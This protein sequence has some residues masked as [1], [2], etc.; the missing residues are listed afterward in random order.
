MRRWVRHVA[1]VAVLGAGFVVAPLPTF[2]WASDVETRT[3]QPVLEA[4][5]VSARAQGLVEEPAAVDEN[6]HAL[7]GDPA[8]ARAAGESGLDPF[9]AIG[10][11]TATAPSV[12]TAIRTLTDGR[13]SEW[14]ELSTD[15]DHRPDGSEGDGSRPG[16]TSEPLFVERADGYEL[17]VPDDVRSIEV[18]LVT[19]VDRRV[20]IVDGTDE[21]GSAPA[22][23][24][25]SSWGARA[26]KSS[27]ADAEEIELAVV[28]HSVNSN[29]YS[30]AS[31][32]A[33]LRAIQAYHMDANGWSDIAYNFAV[34]RFG[35]IWEGRAGGVD[36]AIIG[37]HAYGFN[38]A[39]TG[40]VVLGDYTSASPSSASVTSVASLLAWKLAQ[41]QTP[42]TGT[43]TYRSSVATHFGP[44]G[45]PVRLRRIVGHRDVRQTGCPGNALYSRLPTIRSDVNART[46]GAQAEAPARLI[47]GDRTGDGRDDLLLYR[48]G[49]SNDR[50]LIGTG[51]AGVPGSGPPG[52]AVGSTPV[53][54]L[55]DP[56]AGD[57]D[58][59]G[60]SD[61]LWYAPG[62]TLD[63]LWYGTSDGGHRSVST[64]IVGEY[65]PL[66]GDFD[67]DGRS[68]VYWYG[69]YGGSDSIWYGRAGGG[70]TGA[71]SRVSGGYEAHVGD[72][73]GDGASD[74]LWYAP[75]SVPDYVWYGGARF[76]SVQNRVS[77]Y[78]EP[79]IGDFSGDGRDD[80][81]WYRRGQAS[82]HL[83]TATASRRF[84]SR[85]Q[86]VSGV[87]DPFVGDF[88]D[89]GFDDIFWNAPD[90]VADYQWMHRSSGYRNADARIDGGRRMVA[91]D[92]D[93]NGDDEIFSLDG[94]D[95]G[96]LWDRNGDD[97]SSRPIG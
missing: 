53:S 9:T 62:N 40:V 41:H 13:W 47:E 1:V 64:R 57:F 96:R 56:I 29:G 17:Q 42:T 83:W 32:P 4:I 51:G 8:L 81:F 14:R 43:V 89:N 54:G 36:R 97:F 25:R 59:D 23:A 93:G 28:H 16:H 2:A 39:S 30:Q 46:P 44:A 27:P 55:Y 50:S 92:A 11:T 37:G 82:D 71:T 66:V 91:V 63:Y 21:A 7:A 75:G 3:R 60:R 18:H 6:A 69:P 76:T 94:L 34:D 22:I 87:Y 35:G 67:G 86:S 33:M 88:D 84:S 77:G 58:G 78:Y 85:E 79:Q 73:D 68:D 24:T 65:E 31:V 19:E 90:G 49:S 48:P 20:E 15:D 5:D 12:P 10:V 52:F 26:P 74:I 61:V 95:S 72:F 80:I 45:T 38:T 70:F